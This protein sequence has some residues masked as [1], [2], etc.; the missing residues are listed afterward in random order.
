L[1]SKQFNTAFSGLQNKT[2]RDR[3]KFRFASDC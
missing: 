1:R 2:H 3:D